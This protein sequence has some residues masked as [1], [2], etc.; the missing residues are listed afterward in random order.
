MA[1]QVLPVNQLVANTFKDCIL[2]PLI[3]VVADGCIVDA[4]VSE[5]LILVVKQTNA[6]KHKLTVKSIYGA[7]DDLI[8]DLVA[9]VGYSMVA[10]ESMR[11]EI[12]S[13]ADIGK[14]YLDFEAGFV[15]T[16]FAVG[17]LK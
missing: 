11:Y 3:P 17:T 15:G 16:I 2:L 9:T 13:G 1:R 12:T 4:G 10:L 8:V 7:A 5:N 6:V 14:I